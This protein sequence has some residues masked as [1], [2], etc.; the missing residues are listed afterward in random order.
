MTNR[1][2]MLFIES[3][4]NKSRSILSRSIVY[5]GELEENICRFGLVREATEPNTEN[6]FPSIAVNVM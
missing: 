1:R 3:N 4:L 6:I 2:V 5:L